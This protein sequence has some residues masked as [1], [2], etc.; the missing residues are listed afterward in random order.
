MDLTIREYDAD[1]DEVNVCTINA[2]VGDQPFA[3]LV[4]RLLG[5]LQGPPT[6]VWIDP[7]QLR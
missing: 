6:T 4:G 1:R 5:A 2:G 3:P 7:E